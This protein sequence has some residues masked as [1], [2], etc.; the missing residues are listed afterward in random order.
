MPGLYVSPILGK[1]QVGVIIKGIGFYFEGVC[2]HF[3][4]FI[5]AK[6]LFFGVIITRRLSSM[7]PSLSTILPP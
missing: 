4:M 1:V 3:H 6:Q 5:H 7:V 2:S